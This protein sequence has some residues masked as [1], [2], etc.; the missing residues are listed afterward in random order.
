MV[1][2]EANTLRRSGSGEIRVACDYL[3]LLY[4]RLAPP[5]NGNTSNSSSFLSAYTLTLY[6]AWTSSSALFNVFLAFRSVFSSHVVQTGFSGSKNLDLILQA[7]IIFSTSTFLR[8]KV[9]AKTS[10]IQSSGQGYLT[11]PLLMKDNHSE[12]WYHVT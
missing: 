4:R 6:S 11:N 12:H 9:Y 10:Y 1:G 7:F 8:L 2:R 5:I 3:S